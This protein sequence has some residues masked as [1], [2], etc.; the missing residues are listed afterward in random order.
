MTSRVGID[1]VDDVPLAEFSSLPS[2]RA[3]IP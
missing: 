3:P 2:E 1:E